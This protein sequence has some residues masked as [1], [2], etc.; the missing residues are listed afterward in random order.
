MCRVC[1][2]G[3]Q[4]LQIMHAEFT[5]DCDQCVDPVDLEVYRR[6]YSEDLLVGEEDK[7]NLCRQVL[8]QQLL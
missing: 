8:P 5:I 6:H 3:A 4:N 7:V 1:K 2:N